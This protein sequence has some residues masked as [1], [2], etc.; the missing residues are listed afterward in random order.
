MLLFLK[1]YLL[2]SPAE[3]VI[4]AIAVAK[5]QDSRVSGA[6]ELALPDRCA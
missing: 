5:Q 4:C 2:L 3:P 1:Q 6:L